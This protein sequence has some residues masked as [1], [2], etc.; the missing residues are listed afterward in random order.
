MALVHDLAESIVGD[1]TPHCPVSKEEKHAME[2]KALQDIVLLL[3]PDTV[4]GEEA[5]ARPPIV[6]CLILVSY[7]SL[8]ISGEGSNDFQM[9]TFRCCL[10]SLLAT[11]SGLVVVLW[12]GPAHACMQRAR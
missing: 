11:A 7:M 12:R 4:A 10:C 6:A 1:I 3:G 5:A 2:L 9:S 8:R